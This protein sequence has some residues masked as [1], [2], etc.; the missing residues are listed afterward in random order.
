LPAPK[1][2]FDSIVADYDRKRHADSQILSDLVYYLK[3]HKKGRYL[4]IGCGTGNYTMAMHEQGYS[5]T[6]LDPSK[7]MLNCARKKCNE[8]DWYRGFSEGMSFFQ[9]GYFNG[10]ICVNAVHH[11]VNIELAFR[12]IYR[13]LNNDSQFV[14]F[15]SSHEQRAGYWLN[16]YFPKIMERENK[17]RPD[18]ADIEHYLRE[19]GFIN[20]VRHIYHIHP[21]LQ[22]FFTYS[23]KDDPQ[24]YLNEKFR[25][26]M[27]T[28]LRAG[29][30][31]TKKGISMLS[32]D[33]QFKRIF[34]ITERYI[35]HN[36]NIGDYMYIVDE[37]I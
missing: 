31:E 11:F 30:G 22:D 26:G 25:N 13:I 19:A 21:N 27:S 8:I 15:T 34:N 12:E 6:G 14:I 36:E 29:E 32:R 9:D 17:I 28:F 20:V 1:L 37:K 18:V 2:L 16:H 33:I 10:A 24:S 35:K 7:K 4:D 3:A 5:V 23:K